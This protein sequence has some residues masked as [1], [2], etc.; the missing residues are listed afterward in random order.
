MPQ[1]SPAFQR[2]AKSS[3][4]GIEAGRSVSTCKYEDI[5]AP[6]TTDHFPPVRSKQ[7][8]VPPSRNTC[9]RRSQS[10]WVLWHLWGALDK[11]PTCSSHSPQFGNWGDTC[12]VYSH[13]CMIPEHSTL[14][15]D[16]FHLH[17]DN[18][19]WKHW[20]IGERSRESGP[21]HAVFLG[22]QGKQWAMSMQFST[23]QSDIWSLAPVS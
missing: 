7:K 1:A 21:W 6:E 22:T 18:H 13:H 8:M 19:P 12:S 17:G 16:P 23:F 2:R 10:S 11:S 3:K 5:L 20:K 4:T 9:R 15:P 14:F